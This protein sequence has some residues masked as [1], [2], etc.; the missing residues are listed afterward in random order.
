MMLPTFTRQKEY[1]TCCEVF[2][3][4]EQGYGKK[5]FTVPNYW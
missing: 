1:S 2:F 3:N 5:G 4:T